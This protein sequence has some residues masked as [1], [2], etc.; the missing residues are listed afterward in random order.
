[1]SVWFIDFFKFGIF[2][3]SQ[4]VLYLICN[5]KYLI[6]GEL[7]LRPLVDCEGV[8]SGRVTGESPL[9]C[10]QAH[11]VDIQRVDEAWTHVS[12]ARSSQ[13]AAARLSAAVQGLWWRD[14]PQGNLHCNKNIVVARNLSVGIISLFIKESL[15]KTIYKS[16][17]WL[18]D[19][20]EVWWQIN[21]YG[22]ENG[23]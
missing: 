19:E 14:S 3:R 16:N 13:G 23:D 18:D 22:S 15:N 2:L 20:L 1:M 21:L 7:L 11:G 12:G 8:G 6:V 17:I 10:R 4:H 5:A 9:W